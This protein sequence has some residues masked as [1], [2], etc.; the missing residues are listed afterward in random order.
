VIEQEP[1]PTEAGIPA[2]YWPASGSIRAENL[3]ARY[4]PDGPEVLH[5]LSF[6]IKSGERVG[7]VGR[8]GSGKSSLTLSLL[9]M[10]PTSGAVFYDGVATASINLDAL[11]TNITIIPQQPE[12]M[13]G[14]LRHN[15]DPFG[16]HDDALLN[17][18]LKAAG[19]FS[20]QT[21][22][23][24]G[25]ITLDTAVSSAGGNF[26]L[27]QRQIIAL[28]RAIVRRSKVLILD[29]ATAAIGIF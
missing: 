20:L 18:A 23:E 21:D 4:S 16:Q 11:R 19:L 13:S 1:K 15:L 17:D 2:A 6:E 9:R 5:D 8:T 28:A 24:E 22:D 27:G 26:S 25:R 14:S 12:L 10:I 29:E 3:C 7:V